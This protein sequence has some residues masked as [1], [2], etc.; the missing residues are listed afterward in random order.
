M[1]KNFILQTRHPWITLFEFLL[2]AFLGSLLTLARQE[3]EFFLLKNIIYYIEHFSVSAVHH[4]NNTVWQ[5]HDVSFLD[6]ENLC[7][8]GFV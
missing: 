7:K 2:P 4:P 3:C 8:E 1:K 6:A 5:P